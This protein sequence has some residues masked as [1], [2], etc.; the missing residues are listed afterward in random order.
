MTG[1][2]PPKQPPPDLTDDFFSTSNYSGGSY[3]GAAGGSSY[4]QQIDLFNDT[5]SSSSR[6]PHF[7][8]GPARSGAGDFNSLLDQQPLH[9][10]ARMGDHVG[11]GADPVAQG[12]P[13]SALGNVSLGNPVG[14]EKELN[15]FFKQ[16]QLSGDGKR[17]G[18]QAAMEG[19]GS[20]APQGTGVPV[21]EFLKNAKHPV[22]C[23]FHLLFKALW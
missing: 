13:A 4:T 5:S 17:A 2:Q 21:P 15:D 18:G 22:V 14:T 16:E 7:N 9:G 1:Y 11:G 20:Q 10:G 8:S 23:L 3:K 12:T 19:F 6:P